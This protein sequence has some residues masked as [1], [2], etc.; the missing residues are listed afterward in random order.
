MEH[1][2]TWEKLKSPEY[3]PIHCEQDEH[4]WV[5]SFYWSGRLAYWQCAGC[6]LM[7]RETD[8]PPGRLVQINGWI[9][10]PLTLTSRGARP[11]T[12][13]ARWATDR[14]TV[15]IE[16]APSSIHFVGLQIPDLSEAHT[17]EE[18]DANGEVQESYAPSPLAHGCQCLLASLV[19]RE[20]LSSKFRAPRQL[21]ALGFCC[22]PSYWRV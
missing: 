6:G 5:A 22:Q 11:P 15:L 3:D 4:L 16:S 19:Q 2:P 9:E 13:T 10:A 20:H 1:K 18:Y 21:G 8:E 17:Y 7:D 14:G 12:S